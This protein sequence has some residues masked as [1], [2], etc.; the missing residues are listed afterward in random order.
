MFEKINE[1]LSVYDKAIRKL[2]QITDKHEDTLNTVLEATVLQHLINDITDN[3]INVLES[4]TK[5]IDDMEEYI[6]A[7]TKR[8]KELERR[9]K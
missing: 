2:V 6:D 3:R 5:R 9:C 7:L 1:K 8:V 4:T